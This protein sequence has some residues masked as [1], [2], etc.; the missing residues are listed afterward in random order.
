MVKMYERVFN[1]SDE[2]AGESA[3]KGTKPEIGPPSP[4]SASAA[5]SPLPP[6]SSAPQSPLPP[7]G[8]DYLSPDAVTLTLEQ[9]KR[10]AVLPPNI[11]PTIREMYLDDAVFKQIFSM[12]KD[13]FK[14]LKRWKKDELKK[15]MDIF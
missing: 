9:V 5:S 7:S 14:A 13:Q 1:S 8:V 2:S 15:K 3:G 6:S 10:G 4:V 12:D 11:D